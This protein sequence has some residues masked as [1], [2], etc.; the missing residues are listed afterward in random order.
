MVTQ[1]WLTLVTIVKDDPD[2]FSRTMASI[3]EQN[4]DGVEFVI[5]DSSADP[6]VIPDIVNQSGVVAEIHST[7]PKGIYPAMNAGLRAASGTYVYFA[8]AGDAFANDSAISTIRKA[9]EGSPKWLYGQV[10]F[11]QPDGASI[12]P[13]PFDYAKER[14][15]SFSN[16]RFPPHQG[17]IAQTQLVRNLGGFDTSY[18]IGS[19]Y[20]LF[21]RL[22]LVG[23]PC[24]IDAVIADFYVG[25][26]STVAWRES[27]KEFH[28]ARRSILKP[29]GAMAMREQFGTWSQFTRMSAAR[30]IKR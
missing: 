12:T 15:R 23:D 21:L 19:D 27:L 6:G 1:P 7:P 22:S 20:A 4:L 26:L 28:A 16:G 25:G 24:E 13:P 14:N 9:T 8:N 5:I 29:T 17:T 30:F 3:R 18:R 10:R 2:G 11:I